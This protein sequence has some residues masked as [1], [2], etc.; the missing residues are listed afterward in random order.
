MWSRWDY[1]P[2]VFEVI[3]SMKSLAKIV[4]IL[5]EFSMIFSIH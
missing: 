4:E 5:E 3:D 1:P 2:L